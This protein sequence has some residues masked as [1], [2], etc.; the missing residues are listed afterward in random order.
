MPFVGVRSGRVCAFV[1]EQTTSDRIL[2]RKC[3]ASESSSIAQSNSCC[4]RP[5]VFHRSHHFLFAELIDFVD[6]KC[7]YGATIFTQTHA[8]SSAVSAHQ[9][10][11]SPSL[12]HVKPHFFT[13]ILRVYLFYVIGRQ[14][15]L[16]EKSAEAR[17]GKRHKTLCMRVCLCACAP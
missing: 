3:A 5:L 10:S 11:P 14:S 15:L 16:E 17:S 12:S 6:N 1:N 7:A 13:P 9:S 2:R 8:H 4:V